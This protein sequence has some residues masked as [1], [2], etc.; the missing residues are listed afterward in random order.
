MD[1]IICLID[2]GFIAQMSRN[3]D[4]EKEEIDF[5]KL[6]Q[7]MAGNIPMLRTYYY[8]CAPYADNEPNDYQKVLQANFENFKKTLL[9]TPQLEVKLGRIQRIFEN[10]RPIYS[11]KGIDT[12]MA[13]DLVTF[14]TK[15]LITH[16]VLMTG[17]ADLVPAIQVSKNEGVIVKVISFEEYNKSTSDALRQVADITEKWN[18][19]IIEKCS[20]H[21]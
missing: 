19:R 10:G 11:Q 21:I 20:N 8:D 13:I 3:Y 1:R 14:S 15:K 12:L 7:K 5:L 6:I 4:I 16:A 2:G 17:D 18:K 9:Q